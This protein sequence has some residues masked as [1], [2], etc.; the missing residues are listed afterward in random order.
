ML[1][2][3]GLRISAKQFG[4]TY[5]DHAPYEIL[6]NNVIDFNDILKI[7]QVED[8]LEK[9]WNNHRMDNAVEYIVSTC[10][11]TPFDFFQR[12][13]AYW[14]QQGW[15]RIGHQLEDL[16]IRL[17]QFLREEN[18][19]GRAIAEGLMKFDYLLNIRYKPRKPWWKPSLKKKKKPIFTRLYSLNP[20][21]PAARLPVCS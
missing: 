20:K 18:V 5:M 16:F 12:F 9:Y 2:G 17:Q 14:D 21:W 15:S 8:V 7:K 19:E 13:G 10:F 11:E 1:R 3:T 6:G 4:Y